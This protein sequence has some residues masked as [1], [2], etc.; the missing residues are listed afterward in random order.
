LEQLSQVSV[1]PL[2]D[3]FW[4]QGS[5]YSAALGGHASEANLRQLGER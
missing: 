2:V 4:G 1:D 5:G 3:G